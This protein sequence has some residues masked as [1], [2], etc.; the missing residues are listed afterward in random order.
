MASIIDD[1]YE[2]IKLN[3]VEYVCSVVFEARNKDFVG[4]DGKTV[5]S[6]DNNY[7]Y[8]PIPWANIKRFSYTD[9]ISIVGLTGEMVITNE[10]NAFTGILSRPDDFFV[11]FF[12][13]S[14]TEQPFTENIYFSIVETIENQ[15]TKDVSDITYR[16]ILKEAFAEVGASKNFFGMLSSGYFT[17]LVQKDNAA[18]DKDQ[19]NATA[20]AENAAM[21]AIN[22]VGPEL[23]VIRAIG[24]LIGC[25]NPPM[26]GVKNVD[27]LVSLIVSFIK[28]GL[29]YGKKGSSWLFG[30]QFGISLSASPDNNRLISMDGSVQEYFATNHPSPDMADGIF[31]NIT[32]NMSCYD[33]LSLINKKYYTFKEIARDGE[34]RVS[35]VDLKYGE[36]CYVR[37]ENMTLAP[38]LYPEIYSTGIFKKT[39]K[40][41]N[42]ARMITLKNLRS[43]FKNCFKE[44]RFLELFIN[45][46]HQMPDNAKKDERQPGS[47]SYTNESVIARSK[48][49]FI[50][51]ISFDDVKSYPPVLNQIYDMWRDT[52]GMRMDQKDIRE[53]HS[54]WAFTEL[55]GIFNKDYLCDVLA[56]NIPPNLKVSKGIVFKDMPFSI[57]KLAAG[58]AAEIIASIVYLNTLIKVNLPGQLY[59]KACEIIYI[60][61]YNQAKN[62]PGQTYAFDGLID[63]G[64]Y[65]ITNVTHTFWNGFYKN[66][67]NLTAF[68]RPY[69]TGKELSNEGAKSITG[70]DTVKNDG[71]VETPEEAA[72]KQADADAAK[73]QADAVAQNSMNPEVTDD[74]P[75]KPLDQN[76][77]EDTSNG[78]QIE[79]ADRTQAGEMATA[80][81]IQAS[82]TMGNGTDNAFAWPPVPDGEIEEATDVANA[83]IAGQYVQLNT[84]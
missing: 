38:D 54:F 41:Y 55:M 28:V 72:K 65:F 66:S 84:Q 24:R 15:T 40:L 43:V 52:A 46:E 18:T 32:P 71:T 79:A 70:Y 76:L 31:Q 10:S 60:D 6:G 59:R 58:I 48:P 22:T 67:M 35:D 14:R 57:E 21:Q 37:S 45:S 19:L 39:A 56:A 68:G 1:S 53:P 33:V 5:K 63:K 2:Y 25:S 81:E 78:P 69:M 4:N 11:H 42:G 36:K 23:S 80:E 77:L 82:L 3:G 9:D 30:D 8:I 64:Y 50:T 34:N 73:K 75:D 74:T 16:L 26:R 27:E 62:L 12:L 83:G 20:E 61:T 29:T 44:D 47:N 51:P 13:T 7:L 49:M 17:D